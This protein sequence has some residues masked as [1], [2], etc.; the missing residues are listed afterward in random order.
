MY[1][2]GG[3]FESVGSGHRERAS[4]G[5]GV[6]LS[7]FFSKCRLFFFS[8]SQHAMPSLKS[9]RNDHPNAPDHSTRR[10]RA[11]SL[12]EA[13][14]VVLLILSRLLIQSRAIS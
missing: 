2:C 4:G 13:L 6:R 3:A 8:H 14:E 1:V 5:Y 11:E 10:S 7:S 9:E 12:S